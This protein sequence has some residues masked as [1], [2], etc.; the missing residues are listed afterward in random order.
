MA[1]LVSNSRNEE[2]GGHLCDRMLST[3][4]SYKAV[5]PVNPGLGG[6]SVCCQE[7]VDSSVCFQLK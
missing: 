1:P 3:P 5:N 6:F 7:V 2:R 4:P